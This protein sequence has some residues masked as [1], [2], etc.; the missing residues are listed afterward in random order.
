M[1]GMSIM[2]MGQSWSFLVSSA[3]TAP[4]FRNF[5][6]V[7]HMAGLATAFPAL[8]LFSVEEIV[9]SYQ[10]CFFVNSD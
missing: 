1:V 3:G 9:F 8:A 10:K 6:S 4:G 2:P 7:G 5:A